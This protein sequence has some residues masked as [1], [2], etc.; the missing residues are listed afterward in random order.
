MAAPKLLDLL[1]L[2]EAGF[3][4]R[5]RKSPVKRAKRAGLLRNVCVALCNWAHSSTVSAL[6]AALNDDEWLIRGHAAWALGRVGTDTARE[7]MKQR[8]AIERSDFVTGE[9]VQALETRVPCDEVS[10]G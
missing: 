1:A 8:L 6:T 3:R 10:D 9:L 5:F 4:R 7:A 2:D